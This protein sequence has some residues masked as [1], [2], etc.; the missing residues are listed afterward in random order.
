MSQ[1]P[2]SWKNATY[3]AYAILRHAAYQYLSEDLISHNNPSNKLEMQ[4]S[5][6]PDLKSANMSIDTS[7]LSAEINNLRLNRFIS[8]LVAEHPE[9]NAHQRYAQEL[10]RGDQFRKYIYI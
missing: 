10:F 6:A 2:D 5:L 4:V 7:L 3:K 9:Y 1:I 8:A